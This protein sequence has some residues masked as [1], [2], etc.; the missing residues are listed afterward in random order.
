MSS[1]E[2][3]RRLLELPCV[4]QNIPGHIVLCFRSNYLISNDVL[5]YREPVDT[6][7]NATQRQL[8]EIQQAFEIKQRVLHEIKAGTNRYRILGGQ[9]EMLVRGE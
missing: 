2:Q 1:E 3:R 8:A 7:I 4:N 5:A 9:L 6:F